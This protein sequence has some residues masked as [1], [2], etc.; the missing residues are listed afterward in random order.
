MR[1]L[2]VVF[3]VLTL[4]ILPYSR[5]YA[6]FE[7]DGVIIS[8]PDDVFDF[9]ACPGDEVGGTLTVQNTGETR[10][11]AYVTVGSGYGE[12]SSCTWLRATPIRFTLK[13]LQSINLL[14]VGNTALIKNCRGES[15]R[16][17]IDIVFDSGKKS[18][19]VYLFNVTMR[20]PAL[21]PDKEVISLGVF[22]PPGENPQPVETVVSVRLQNDGCRYRGTIFEVGDIFGGY[23]ERVSIAANASGTLNI[24]VSFVPKGEPGDVVES[25][26]Y[27][28]DTCTNDGVNAKVALCRVFY[29]IND[30]PRFI[31][32]KTTIWAKPP[33]ED[34]LTIDIEFSDKD[35]DITH[36]SLV[37]N[38]EGV[39]ILDWNQSGVTI[40]L[41][42]EI[43]KVGEKL[44]LELLVKDHC[45]E[46]VHP[47]EVMI[48]S[49]DIPNFSIDLGTERIRLFRGRVIDIP[50]NIV[51][52]DGVT[53]ETKKMFENPEI[54]VS[55]GINEC[56]ITI[57]DEKPEIS[58]KANVDAKPIESFLIVTAVVGDRTQS[59]MVSMYIRDNT[60]PE[61][62]D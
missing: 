58:I 38:I 13:P 6:D 16:I 19:H 54:L 20:E 45:H 33:S 10:L 61:D 53:E 7:V 39:E 42:P 48:D 5:T 49:T 43:L 44:N 52:P 46:V 26:F 9:E 8:A 23:S 62:D 37:C 60:I 55:T 51:Y 22:C 34:D 12:T 47:V 24:P 29:Q 56:K 14:F 3:V 15:C 18:Q 11:K 21:I 27:A 40:K 4:L 31:S 57:S 32:D 2:V 36:V 17:V 28:V 50:V 35:E 41:N 59:A 25:V 30:Y 1:R